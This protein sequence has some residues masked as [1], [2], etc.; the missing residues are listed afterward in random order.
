MQPSQPKESSQRQKL[1]P[2]VSGYARTFVRLLAHQVVMR[3]AEPRLVQE[4]KFMHSK[5]EPSWHGT[6][7]ILAHG[8]I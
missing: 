2:N 6:K 1:I 3:F 7:V 8:L 4:K 5:L